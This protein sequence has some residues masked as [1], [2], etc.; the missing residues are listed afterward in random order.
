MW[1]SVGNQCSIMKMWDMFYPLVNQ[2]LV[3]AFSFLIVG[4]FVSLFLSINSQ[5][6]CMNCVRV[7]VHYIKYKYEMEYRLPPSHNK[8]QY[9][10]HCDVLVVVVVID[11]DFNWIQWRTQTIVNFRWGEWLVDH[12]TCVFVCGCVLIEF[13]YAWMN[14]SMLHW[15]STFVQLAHTFT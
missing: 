15:I 11:L 4:L 13:N 14:V 9:S 10:C 5:Y 7:C 2:M 6:D 12:V 1:P 8:K 3:S